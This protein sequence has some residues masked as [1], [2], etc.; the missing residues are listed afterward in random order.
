MLNL[1]GA[2]GGLANNPGALGGLIGGIVLV[3]VGIIVYIFVF[4]KK[5]MAKVAAKR[6]ETSEK[7][8][9]AAKAQG[10][11]GDVFKDKQKPEAPK[12]LTAEEEKQQKEV[13][14]GDK[15]SALGAQNFGGQVTK[16][17]EP[18]APAPFE[19]EESS[20]I[21]NPHDQFKR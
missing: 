12:Q 15:I 3:A 9:E 6:E 19:E 2:G 11:V 18:K 13:A 1:F 5:V 10:I 16:V 21:Y 4:H 20:T 14:R 17:E 8:K 7:K